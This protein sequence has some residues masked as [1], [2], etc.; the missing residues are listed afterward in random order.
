[1]WGFKYTLTT[2][3][4]SSRGTQLCFCHCYISCPFFRLMNLKNSRDYRYERESYEQAPSSV[5]AVLP[6]LSYFSTKCHLRCPEENPGSSFFR[7]IPSP[8]A[9]Y[10]V[11][12]CISHEWA[13]YHHPPLYAHGTILDFSSFKCRDCLLLIFS[14][15]QIFLYSS[16]FLLFK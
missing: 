7:F 13:I 2:I 6:S 15:L 8:G 14:I 11:R 9:V 12:V 16:Y 1:M 3:V 5:V 4:Y 10:S